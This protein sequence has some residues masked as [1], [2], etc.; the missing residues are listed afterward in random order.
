VQDVKVNNIVVADH[1]SFNRFNREEA[2]ELELK[3]GRRTMQ[4]LGRR[5][6]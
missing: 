3:V 2:I 5:S 1:K 6:T 4:L